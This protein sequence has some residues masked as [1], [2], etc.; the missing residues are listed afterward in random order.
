MVITHVLSNNRRAR[1]PA[2]ALLYLNG[3]FSRVSRANKYL[4]LQQLLSKMS[5]RRPDYNYRN[6]SNA[7]G[8]QSLT[9]IYTKPQIMQAYKRYGVQDGLKMLNNP[10]MQTKMLH[11]NKNYN[12]NSAAIRKEVKC[13]DLSFNIS[14]IDS[15]TNT[16]NQIAP[17]N[18]IQPGTG[19]WNR[20]GKKIKMKS[21]R[22][23][24]QIS[25]NGNSA[26]SGQNAS[27]RCCLVYDRQPSSQAIPTFNQIFGSTDQTGAES[28]YGIYDNLRVDNTER[29][30]VV[31]DDVYTSDLQS[32]DGSITSC[33]Y[34]IIVDNF[35]KL[36]DL[37]TVFSGQSNPC[38]IADI[39]S[40]ALYLIFRVD[41]IINIVTNINQSVLRLRYY[42]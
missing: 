5:G 16:N 6:T 15:T 29:F 14:G 21:V 26:A 19:S 17:V 25:F 22:Y 7:Y 27:V 8:R 28:T 13:C 1:A 41:S 12:V 38:T 9:D 11:Y 36:K 2:R 4:L 23:K 40:G 39:S 10:T 34:Q 18:C 33:E 32:S 35:V 37:D 31:K 20:I 42:D 24:Y 30:T 3:F